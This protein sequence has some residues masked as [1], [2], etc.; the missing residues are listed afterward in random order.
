MKVELG[1]S[2]ATLKPTGELIFSVDNL[3]DFTFNVD[4]SRYTLTYKF[5]VVTINPY[6]NK[7]YY[8]D[9]NTGVI[10]KETSNI[11]NDGL[12]TVHNA[13]LLQTIQ[14]IDTRHRGFPNN[15]WVLE[16]D[17]GNKQIHSKYYNNGISWILRPEITDNDDN[18]ITSNGNATTTHWYAQRVWD[19]YSDIFT[20]SGMDGNNANLR[21]H[22]VESDQSFNAFYSTHLGIDGLTFMKS[23]SQYAGDFSDVVGHEFT[24]GVIHY[25]SELGNQKEPG[26]LGESFGDIFGVMYKRYLYGNYANTF[27]DWV[28]A[29]NTPASR[30]LEDPKSDGVH[31]VDNGNGY[32][33]VT[34][35]PDTY[36]G[37][38][39]LP[40]NVNIDSYGIH[41][42]CGVQNHWFYVLSVG[43]QGV[44]DNNDTYDVQGIGSDNALKITYW[45]MVNILQS[46]SQFSDARE[47]SITSSML[48]F[49]EC[50][51]EFIQT[52]NAWYAVGVGG[53]TTCANA[54]VDEL[55]DNLYIY[56]N[57]VKDNI[58]INWNA[59]PSFNMTIYD[60]NGKLIKSYTNLSSNTAIN[61]D[62]FSKGV[63]IIELT[64]EEET[65]RKKIVKY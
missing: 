9:A 3:T 48:F 1:D 33:T 25:S 24:H 43:E 56:P 61:L 63:Y 50:S 26:A 44:N 22:V 55:T 57:P 47:G 12:A 65:I 2:N 4:G 20:L 40:T 11:F 30:S 13:P 6:D 36:G 17:N 19:W 39:W 10:L 16:T 14:T 49:G 37:E 58:L 62:V 27:N 23:S 18:W 8:I 45:S 59:K 42:N 34:G 31:Y 64:D 5:D 46:N 54:N 32:V 7:S 29:N 51:N 28:I 60:I 53:Q 38:F 21:I 41:T 35:Q 15:D 52:T